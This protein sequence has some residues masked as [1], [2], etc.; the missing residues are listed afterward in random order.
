MRKL[1][2][3]L[4]SVCLLTVKAQWIGLPAPQSP[5]ISPSYTCSLG[6]TTPYAIFP[7][8]NG[9][10]RYTSNCNMASNGGLVYFHYSAN[11]LFSSVNLMPWGSYSGCCAFGNFFADSDSSFSFVLTQNLGSGFVGYVSSNTSTISPVLST[12]SLGWAKATCLTNNL[13]YCLGQLNSS[14]SMYV[15]RTKKTLNSVVKKGNYLFNP[16]ID[17]LQFVNDST[18]FTLATFK[19]NPAKTTLLKTIDYGATWTPVIVDSLVGF[20][21]YHVMKTGVAYI[22]NKYGDTYFS[23]NFGNTWLYKS[24]APATNYYAIRFMND[25]CGYIGGATGSLFKTVNRGSSWTV[26]NSNTTQ[27]I[28]SLHTFSNVAYFV[29]A[30][31]KVFKNSVLSTKFFKQTDPFPISAIPCNSTSIAPTFT[32]G[33]NVVTSNLYTITVNTPPCMSNFT[34][35]T[36]ATSIGFTFPCVG[37]YTLTGYDGAANFLGTVNYTVVESNVFTPTITSLSDT[38]CNGNSTTLS[39][40][41]TTSGYTISPFTW[42]TG[43]NFTPITVNP[44]ATTLYTLSGLFTTGTRTCNVSASKNLVVNSCVG[45]KEIEKTPFKIYP[46]PATSILYLDGNASEI[47]NSSLEITNTLGQVLLSA[48]GKHEIVI[49][50]LSTGTYFLKIKTNDRNYFLKFVKE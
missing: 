30:A 2:L 34:F 19:S 38:I 4:L 29:D 6:L 14:D 26:E 1:L 32:F 41:N 12:G 27:T 43:Q 8:G 10:I 44:N 5:T 36:S 31:K 16:A 33:S 42:S 23:N 7:V 46:N 45:I 15:Y 39:F 48:Q 40:S 35:A 13:I 9:K 25:S 37:V 21:D 17:K 47:L 3:T 22:C 18:G 49:D 20:T 28:Q 50:T 11:D 24:T